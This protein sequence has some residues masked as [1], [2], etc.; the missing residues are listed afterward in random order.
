MKVNSMSLSVSLCI[1][2]RSII[3]LSVVLLGSHRYLS[4]TTAEMMENS[5]YSP[6]LQRLS[7]HNVTH[8][9][10]QNTHPQKM[11]T[12]WRQGK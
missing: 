10:L 6:K 4:V 8:S 2:N 11:N 3:I 5:A 7:K 12:A 1:S 9:F